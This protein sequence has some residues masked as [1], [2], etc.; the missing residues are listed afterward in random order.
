MAN[1][2]AEAGDLLESLGVAA[3]D[4][5][6]VEKDLWAQVSDYMSVFVFLCSA[7]D[8]LWAFAGKMQC[9]TACA[10]ALVQAQATSGAA[11]NT[12]EAAAGVLAT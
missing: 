4:A 11:A 3:V 5:S 10:F 7:C 9:L 8:V 6:A 2:G 12:E 1:G